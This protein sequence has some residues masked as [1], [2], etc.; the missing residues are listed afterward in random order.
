M[1]SSRYWTRLFG[2]QLCHENYNGRPGRSAH[3][4]LHQ[5]SKYVAEGRSIVVDMDLETF[6]DQSS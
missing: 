5:A 2:L 6:F 4:A 3:D 1:C